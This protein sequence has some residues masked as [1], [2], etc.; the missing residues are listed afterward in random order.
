VVADRA[1]RQAGKRGELLG[2][3]RLV[4]KPQDAGAYVAYAMFAGTRWVLVRE[5]VP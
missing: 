1:G 5:I 3:A 2:G 4:E